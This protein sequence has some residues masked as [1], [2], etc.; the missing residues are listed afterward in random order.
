MKIYLK[1]YTAPAYTVKNINLYFDLYETKTS[2]SSVLNLQKIENNDLVLNGENLN[3]IS[4]QLNSKNFTD[5]KLT[6][7]SL[8]LFSKDLPENFELKIKVEI[9]PEQN[10]SCEGLYLSEGIFCTQCEAESFR[11]ITYM[12]D[13]PDVM[14]IYTVEIEAEKKKYPILLSN[15]DQIKKQD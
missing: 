2:V 5:Y 10:K 6:D 4:L 11:K 9:N 14:T 13:R 15:G 1:D 7:K 8:T 12:L 3:L